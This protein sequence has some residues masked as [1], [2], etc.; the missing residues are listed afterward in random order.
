[1]TNWK[2]LSR[3]FPFGIKKFWY[4][5][6]FSNP[7]NF[8]ILIFIR[9]Q[10][11]SE[12]RFAIL[13]FKILVLYL[14]LTIPFFSAQIS[15]IYTE[16]L[17]IIK[18]YE[19]RWFSVR[20]PGN[21]PSDR[22]HVP[23]RH[24]AF[25]ARVRSARTAHGVKWLLTRDRQQSGQS[26]LLEVVP[27]LR[28]HVGVRRQPRWNAIICTPFRGAGPCSLV[29]TTRDSYHMHECVTRIV[30]THLEIS[31]HLLT[32]D[33]NDNM[34]GKRDRICLF[35]LI[36]IIFY[37]RGIKVNALFQNADEMLIAACWNCCMISHYSHLL[38]RL[39]Y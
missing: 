39:F 31:L 36:A 2:S 33:S 16:E 3:R 29:Y 28:I 1:M 25:L 24:F 15:V 19:Y 10:L 26:V 21:F 5:F 6:W 13:N 17:N 37:A 14:D 9:I 38:I 8:G 22:S 32:F 18:K 27:L 11:F 23:P 12:F 35:S 7:N 20:H 30:V 4:W 34:C